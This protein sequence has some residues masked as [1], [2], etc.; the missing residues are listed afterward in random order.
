MEALS[1]AL[2]E[3]ARTQDTAPDVPGQ[4][5]TVVNSN[6]TAR[7]LANLARVFS[8]FSELQ[9]Q[10]CEQVAVLEESVVQQREEIVEQIA[11]IPEMKEKINW[12][13]A[14]YYEQS[15]KDEAVRDRLTRV[16]RELAAV[17]D[18]VRSLSEFQANWKSTFEQL[19]EVLWRGLARG[20]RSAEAPA[21]RTD[22]ERTS[23]AAAAL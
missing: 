10:L 22:V 8:Q 23:G 4:R 13:I 5:L 15:T 14:T 17:T 12:L 1:S 16:E 9:H 11:A 21:G 7:P 6:K 19:A 2:P 3:E 18:T 20:P